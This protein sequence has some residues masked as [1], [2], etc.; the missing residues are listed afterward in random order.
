MARNEQKESFGR[1]LLNKGAT[2]GNLRD[3]SKK[4]F[5]S[6]NNLSVVLKRIVCA[7]EEMF[8]C[9]EPFKSL[10]DLDVI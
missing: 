5:G 8:E 7:N 3:V 9:E 2:E 4:Y 10:K 1:T 6:L